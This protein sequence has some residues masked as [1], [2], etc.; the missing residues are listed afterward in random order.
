MEYKRANR[1][2]DQLQI[3][4]ADILRRKV[5]D[6]RVDLVT[7][8]GVDVTNDL[9]HARVFVSVLGAGSADR[10]L[11]GLE[12]AGGFIRSE[13]G[14]RLPL[15]YVPDLSFRIDTTAQRAE[16]IEQLLESIKAR[17]EDG[18]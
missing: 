15:R 7:V 11:K 9:R 16:H 10:A 5:K 2:G 6:P 4:I 17:D 8:M 13:L 3:E 12:R 18:R 14:R 1:L